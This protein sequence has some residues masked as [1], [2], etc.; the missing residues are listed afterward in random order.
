MRNYWL[1]FKVGD[2]VVIFADIG[3]FE[4]TIINILYSKR[5]A[6]IYVCEVIANGN[7]ETLNCVASVLEKKKS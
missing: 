3:I 6:T 4:G 7:I 2:A 1:D 5:Y